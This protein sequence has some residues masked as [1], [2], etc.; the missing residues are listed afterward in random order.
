MPK[1]KR[2]PEPERES[3][4][5]LREGYKRWLK[6]LVAVII[7]LLLI[8]RWRGEKG[9]TPSPSPEA[10]APAITAPA[11]RAP[12]PSRPPEMR[13]ALAPS[14]PAT[15]SPVKGNTPPE[16]ASIRLNPK[17][18][19][20]GTRI[21]AEV[22][23]RD[24]DDDPVSFY[25]EWRKGDTV[26]PYEV[27]SE[28]DTKDFKKGD[29]L[30]LY[31]TP[32]D[33]KE[34]GKRKWSPTIMIAN[35]PPEITSTPPAAISNGKYKYDVK[36]SDPDDDKLSFSLE[37]A[38]PGMTVDPATGHIEWNLSAVTD[39]KVASFNIKVVVSD[40]EAQAFQ[41]FNVGLKKEQR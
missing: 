8:S 18:V 40:S 32:F 15:P 34:M 23:G 2:K 37:G 17:L 9:E 28:L 19:Y 36:A 29:L 10:P 38:P 4:G 21:K 6:Y 1:P 26:L 24:A 33:G 35:R 14:V 13:E 41:T 12:E 20:P 22:E 25:Y 7:I 5:L 16:V 27:T 31:V 30:T 11:T 39:L 3:E